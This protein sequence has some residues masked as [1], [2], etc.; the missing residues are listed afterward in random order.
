MVSKL[1]GRD[2]EGVKYVIDKVARN[3]AHFV[4]LSYPF[5]ITW[6]LRGGMNDS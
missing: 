4:R 3:K 1:D 6:S 2:F 5:K